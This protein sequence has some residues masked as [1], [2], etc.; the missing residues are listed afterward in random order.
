MQASAHFLAHFLVLF[1]AESVLLRGNKKKKKE[2]KPLDEIAPLYITPLY[3][4][5]LYI[6]PR[7][8]APLY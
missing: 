8:I 3:I 6:A 5:P 4:A 1:S 2:E 7:Y